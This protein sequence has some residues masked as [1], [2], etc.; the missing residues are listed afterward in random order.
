MEPFGDL[1]RLGSG[2]S[3][4]SRARLGGKSERQGTQPRNTQAQSSQLPQNR[5]IIAHIA[6]LRLN[7]R[8]RELMRKATK[9]K[10][11]VCRFK[12]QWCIHSAVLTGHDHELQIKAEE[13]IGGHRAGVSK[14]FRDE[15][16]PL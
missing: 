6:F 12:E 8:L 14:A 3:S 7:G 13:P 10:G 5:Q 11:F 4:I 1:S 16:K 2:V 15:A 9:R